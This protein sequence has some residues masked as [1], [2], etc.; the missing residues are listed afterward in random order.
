[1]MNDEP[2]SVD[3]RRILKKDGVSVLALVGLW[4]VI[5]IAVNPIGN[6]P[7]NDDWA[8]GKAVQRLLET[9]VVRIP[10]WSAM[11]HIVQLFWG[12]L[13]CLPFG[14]SFTALRFSTLTLGLVGVLAVYALLREFHPR[15]PIPIL[16]ALLIALNPIYLGLSNTFMTDVP[17]FALF[18]LSLWLFSRGLMR[19]RTK[20]LVAGVVAAGFALMIRQFGLVLFVA[21]GC[22]YVYKKGAALKNVMTGILMA[23]LGVGLQISYQFWLRATGRGSAFFGN[24]VRD[25]SKILSAGAGVVVLESLKRVLEYA[26]YSGMFLFPFLL[27]LFVR[28]YRSWPMAR[29]RWRVGFL[30]VFSAVT[31]VEFALHDIRLPFTNNVMSDLGL[32]PLTLRDA[33]FGPTDFGIPPAMRAL[34]ITLTVVGVLGA[35]LLFVFFFLGGQ[36]IFRKRRAASRPETGTVVLVFSAV[37]IYFF[38]ILARTFFD[39][40][41]LPFWPLFLILAAVAAA[42]SGA[43]KR[44]PRTVTLVIVLLLLAYGG[45][46]VGATHDYLLWNRVRWNATDVLMETDKVW[47]R[48]I[49]G[50]LEFNG[51]NL[52]RLDYQPT[53]GKSWWWVEGDDYCVSFGLIPDYKIAKSYPLKRWLPFG[54]KTI[55]V[56]RKNVPGPTPDP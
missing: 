12:A 56:L 48:Q 35:G 50:G 27:L 17:F 29:R 15:P 34:W 49:D 51:W 44:T 42:D 14:F 11:N 6:F 21:F 20:L 46:A 39:R 53:P 23:A 45:F 1:M 28:Q 22:A 36:R 41:L 54:P 31:L 40:Y 43:V 16:G 25:V 26:I 30:A 47:P 24:P 2:F 7:L 33:A 55:L 13:F 8:Y 32:G 9:G 10:D 38:S 52:F 19:N 37:L 18:V 3:S 5:A 4:I